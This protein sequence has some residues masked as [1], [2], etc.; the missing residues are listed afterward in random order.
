MNQSRIGL[1]CAFFKKYIFVAGGL[2]GTSK[3]LNVLDS[4]ETL[5]TRTNQWT[6]IAY[7]L[8]FARC[9]AQML[10]ISDKMYIV[11]GAGRSVTLEKLTAS[12]GSVDIWN[13]KQCQWENVSE[14]S[15]PRHGHSLGY[16]GIQMVVLGGVSTLY[17]R[18]LSNT[19]CFCTLRSK[20]YS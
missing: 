9:F 2:S 17:N 16:L 6:E 13:D 7:P 14:L 10:V 3:K 19:E 20:Y 18:A 4:V 11:G 5:D 15:I 8:R 1:A 12:A